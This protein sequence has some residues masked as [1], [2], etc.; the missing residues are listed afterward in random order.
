M[1]L[2]L[3][4]Y[5]RMNEQWTIP[6]DMMKELYG[7]MRREGTDRIVF[8]S[9]TV[10]NEDE[11]L[12]ASQSASTHTAVIFQ[13]NGEPAA[14]GWLNNFDRSIAHAHWLCFKSIWGTDMT[15]EAARKC[16]KYWFHFEIEGKPLFEVILGLYPDENKFI[17]E[18]VQSIGFTVIGTIPKLFYNHWD[19]RMVGAVVSY[20]ERRTICHL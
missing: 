17:H 3:I 19:E 15:H 13:E 18:F 7:Q 11:F 2:V 16:L 12:R 9:G 8:Y 10:K 20:I 14:I 4:P 5:I 1:G 6:D